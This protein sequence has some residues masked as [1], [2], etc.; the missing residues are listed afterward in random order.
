MLVRLL[1]GG[2]WKPLVEHSRTSAHCDGE[3]YLPS[4]YNGFRF[5]IKLNDNGV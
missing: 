5:T 2:S 1:S 4:F 3:I